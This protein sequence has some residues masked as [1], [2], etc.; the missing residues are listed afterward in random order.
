MPTLTE[1]EMRLE[2][3]LA[4]LE[5]GEGIQPDGDVALAVREMVLQAQEKRDA[6]AFVIRRAEAMIGFYDAEIETLRM[7]RVAAVRSLD[8]LKAY[9]VDTMHGIGATKLPGQAWTLRLQQN[10]PHVEVGVGAGQLPVDCV[11]VVPETR[12]PN[13]EV[14]GR[15]LK[16]G[17]QVIGCRIVP[18]AYRLVAA[19]NNALP[20]KRE[21]QP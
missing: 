8:R 4:L 16:A 19:P 10:P 12:E 1:I 17:E 20:A 5:S 14:I 11:R 6:V 21:E 7:R 9:I 2:S 13:K 3:L 18:G 15:K